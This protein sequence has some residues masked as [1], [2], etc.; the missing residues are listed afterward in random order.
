MIPIN[1][2]DLKILNEFYHSPNSS[3]HCIFGRLKSG[4]TTF[5]RDFI[6][7]KNYIYFSS[8]NAIE[9]VLFP[10]FVDIV[11]KKFKIHNSSTY[12]DSFEKILT[13][14]NEQNIDEKLVIIFDNFEE[15]IK[16][17]KE[18]LLKL[19]SFWEK[20]Y[21]KK[22]ILLLVSSA[23][24]PEETLYKKITKN[25]NQLIFMENFNFDYIKNRGSLT[26]TD[27]FYIY[28]IFG[29]S[30]YI[31]SFYN[32]KLDFIKNIYQLALQP[33]SPFFEYGF[34][35]LKKDLNEIGTFAS[36][37]YAIAI[38]NNKLG[39]IAAVLK[40]K[41]TYLSRYIQ[42]LQEMMIIRKELPLSKEQIFSKYGRYYINDNYLRFWFCY[43][44]PNIASLGLKKH[45]SVLKELD[46]TII[47]NILT[48]TYCEFIKNLIH[49]KPERYLGFVPNKVGSWWDNNGNNID[50]IAYDTKK[51]V[52][53]M[54]V[55]ESKEVAI[56]RY[57][58]LKEMASHF[59]TPLKRE[60]IIIS[61][62]TYFEILEGK[63]TYG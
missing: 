57:N 61:K 29:A 58:E 41:S 23:Y 9:T 40:L 39:D 51:I 63:I 50:L 32:T 18:N 24:I 7:K 11:N 35:Y 5:L 34:N 15:I 45:Q 3:F 46:D 25:T 60:Y 30:S 56:E 6:V 21:S 10:N 20:Y 14:L 42:K 12:Y 44:Y 55:W 4:K 19:L 28:S 2:D 59:K 26:P 22:P 1:Q 37:L 33:N 16:S 49:L 36:I 17:D 62:N 48:P 31:L 54:I 43:I 47:K 38:G 8:F 52:F 13:L 27:K 53:M